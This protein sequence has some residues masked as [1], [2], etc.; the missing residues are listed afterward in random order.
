MV[1][2]LLHAIA[3][4]RSLLIPNQWKWILATE[5]TG[6]GVTG[7]FKVAGR[8]WRNGCVQRWLLSLLCCLSGSEIKKTKLTYTFF[9]FKM[10]K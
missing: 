7:G 1:M 2:G 9:L 3:E 5:L 6:D 4:R 8:R 10:F